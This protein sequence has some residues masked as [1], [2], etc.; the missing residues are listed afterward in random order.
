MFLTTSAGVRLEY[1]RVP[2]AGL[3]PTIVMLHEGLGSIS[4]WRDF[5]RQVA[6]ATGHD[7]LVYSR[8]G[9]GRSSP[10]E[11]PRAVRFMHDEALVVLPEILD[12]LD[13]RRPI[14]LGH[15]DGGSIALIHAGGSGREVAGLVLLAPH[16]MVEDISVASIAAARV[17]YAQGDFRARLGRHHDNVDGA[18]RGWNEVWLRPE[19]RDWSI[20]Q[21]L[22]RIKCPV[23]AIQG[24]E[25]EYGTMEQVERIGRAIPDAQIL[26]L[27]RCGHSPHRD[28]AEDVLEAIRGFVASMPRRT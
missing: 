19:F 1:E 14:L 24:E 27:A 5:P 16:V 28:R 6:E 20:E 9:Y 7:V 26:K 11:G 13:V 25:D 10:L 21:Y 22:P 4:M 8:Q 15:S 18:F 23:L 12:A 2:G 3:S 17:A